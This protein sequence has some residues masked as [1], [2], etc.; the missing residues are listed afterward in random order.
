MKRCPHVFTVITFY[1]YL[2]LLRCCK[3]CIPERKL[4]LLSIECKREEEEWEFIE[5]CCKYK[6]N[7]TSRIF[8]FVLFILS[9]L[10]KKN[11]DLSIFLE[12]YSKV[13]LFVLISCVSCP[14]R[15]WYREKFFKFWILTKTYVTALI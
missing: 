7:R 12:N 14:L 15:R 5:L 6:Q 2:Y 4:I 11:I 13:R 10:K 9:K 3:L 1:I 8:F